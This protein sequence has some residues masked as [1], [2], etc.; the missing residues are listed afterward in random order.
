VIIP[1]HSDVGLVDILRNKYLGTL[2][3]SGIKFM[4]FLYHNLHAKTMLIDDQLFALGSSN[5]DYRSFRY[6]YEIL[7][8]GIDNKIASMLRVHLQ[9]SIDNSEDFDFA[10][11]QRRPFINKIF[12]W[13]LLPVRHLL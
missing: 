11:W 3:K 12:E 4:Y 8:T 2:H 1:K 9:K 13:M 6:M 5:F 10:K 7:L